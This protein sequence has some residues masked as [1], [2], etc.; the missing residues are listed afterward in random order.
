MRPDIKSVY[1]V[2][3]Y[4][5]EQVALFHYSYYKGSKSTDYDVPDDP[6]C[7]EIDKIEVDGVNMTD[8]LLEVAQDWTM[9]VENE[10]LEFCEE[11]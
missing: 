2:P 11:I 6:N 4:N 9:D 1:E 5:T 7:V 10:I 8:I 3:F